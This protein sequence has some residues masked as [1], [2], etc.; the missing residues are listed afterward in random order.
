MSQEYLLVPENEE[1][2]KKQRGG[3]VRGMQEPSI[4]T[5]VTKAEAT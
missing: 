4:L 2:F 5:E 3:H 1:L